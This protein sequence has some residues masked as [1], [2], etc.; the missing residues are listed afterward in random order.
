MP[1]KEEL[2]RLRYSL[3]ILEND[4]TNWMNHQLSVRYSIG[5]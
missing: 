2:R 1:N 4:Y 5:F 3:S